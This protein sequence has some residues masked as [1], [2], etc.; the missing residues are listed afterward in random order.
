[1]DD[2]RVLGG[3]AVVE[4][5]PSVFTVEL[6]VPSASQSVVLQLQVKS[7]TASASVT[8]GTDTTGLLEYFN[9]LTQS[10]EPLVDGRLSF[11]PGQTSLQVRVPTVNDSL[12]EGSEALVLEATPVSGLSGGAAAQSAQNTLLDNDF[13]ARVFESGL[14]GRTDP[15]PARVSG[16]LHLT[17]D[18][19]QTIGAHLIAPTETVWASINQQPLVWK[20]TAPN[21]LTAYAGSDVNAQVVAVARLGAD[22]SYS[23]ELQAAIYHPVTQNEVDLVFGL[24]PAAGSN[25]QLANLTI[26]VVDDQPRLSGA[27]AAQANIQDTNLLLVIDTSSSMAQASGVDGLSRLQATVRAAEQ[28]LDRYDDVGSVSVRLV[29]FGSS[30]QA[31]GATWMAVDD[32]RRALA[33]LQA[34][35]T[36]E[37]RHDLALQA[38]QTAFE[39]AGRIAGAQ[40]VAYVLTDSQP[41]AQVAQ[42]LSQAE[43][44]GTAFLD[45]HQV[46]AEAMAL[47]PGVNA[48]S[49]DAI[50]H[51]G[52]ARADLHASLAQTFV[53]LPSVLD[54][55]APDTIGG[56]LMRDSAR[57]A[58]GGADGVPHLDSVTIDGQTYRYEVGHTDLSVTTQSGGV[59]HINMLTSDYTYV[60]GAASGTETVSFSITDR[61]GDTASSTLT[62][63]IDPTVTIVGREGADALVVTAGAGT[64]LGGG[65]DDSLTGGSGNDAL[66]GH[67]GNDTLVGGAGSDL[68]AG[69]SGY[70]RMTGGAGSDVFAWHF[71]DL[72]T[73]S[74]AVDT[75]T[76]FSTRQLASGGDVLDLRDLLQGENLINVSGNIADYLRLETVGSGSSLATRID[77]SSHGGFESGTAPIDQ[78]IILE[79]ANLL[80]LSAAGASQQQVI[81]D[82]IAQGRLLVDAT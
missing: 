19:G 61:D 46:R 45:L 67:S 69:G 1:M 43:A 4:G 76:D 72:T 9:P 5:R 68:L 34:S 21:T 27:Y 28:L 71:S 53:Q 82:L 63:R 8:P 18:A 58:A 60:P 47:V 55:L 13:E 59:F 78:Q 54:G 2:V 23:F 41:N 48:A 3:A 10:W 57:G 37:A 16:S 32:A 73:G 81:L 36:D 29:T 44:G 40:N 51:D 26:H 20:E 39:D 38:A 49:L 25:A 79:K 80:A 74:V 35:S 17:D 12:V 70:D 30:A 14:A 77:I 62:L 22:G 6:D 7:A 42:A 64:L 56:N 15:A 52:I 31:S 66:Y 33:A 11:A 65:G 50:A 24:Q 75:I